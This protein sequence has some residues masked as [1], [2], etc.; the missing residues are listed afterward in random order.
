M[1]L[2]NWHDPN[3]E[4]RMYS[5]TT[6]VGRN[7]LHQTSEHLLIRN[8]FAKELE[9]LSNKEPMYGIEE[10]ADQSPTFQICKDE[11]L[12]L[13]RMYTGYMETRLTTFY[14]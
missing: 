10:L 1:S 13:R 5:C 14:K 8:A 3:I 12:S 11:M 4:S 6:I 7:F 2:G 9:L